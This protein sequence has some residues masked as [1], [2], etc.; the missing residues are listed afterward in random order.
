[1]TLPSRI[2]TAGLLWL[3][4]GLAAA[5]VRALVRFND[6]T[7]QVYVSGTYSI[8]HTSNLSSSSTGTGD[9]SYGATVAL[10]YQRHAGLITVNA[11]ASFSMTNYF[12]AKDATYNSFNPTYSVEFDKGTGRLVG[13]LNLSAVRS[14]QADA[15]AQVHDESWNYSAGLTFKYPIISRYSLSGS[16]SYGLLDYTETSGQAALVDLTTIGAS[17]G[18]FYILDDEHDLFATYRWRFQQASSDSSTTDQ[19]LMV[20]VNGKV[21]WEINGNVSIGYQIRIPQGFKDS[22]G[23][24]TTGDFSDWTGTA[25]LTWAVNKQMNFKLQGN[26]DFNTSSTDATTDSMT[27]SLDFTYAYNAKLHGTAGLTGGQVRYLGPFGLV[28][29]PVTNLPTAIHRVDYNFGWNLGAGYTYNDHLHVDFQYTFLKNWS[30]L[31]V[32]TFTSAGWTL[33]FG[34]RW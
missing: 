18:M 24:P 22:E 15:A 27:G 6:G 7:D 34:T 26:K 2:R 3:A 19:A 33:T 20:G 17:L 25:G 5:R 12:Q 10:E 4:L 28:I 8:G 31:G 1:M 23:N 16:L 9:Y 29:D 30:N 11:S 14:S 32:A 21:L 13:A